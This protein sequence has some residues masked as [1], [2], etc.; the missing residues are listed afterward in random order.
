V[1]KTFSTFSNGPFKN[2]KRTVMRFGEFAI[3]P[4]LGH[5][6]SC[7]RGLPTYGSLAHA[8]DRPRPDQHHL[9]EEQILPPA[10][11]RQL[12]ICLTIECGRQDLFLLET[13]ST[14]ERKIQ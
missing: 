1:D 7:L 4:G 6:S 12:V 13:R 9:Q 10:F 2:T 11:N 14:K 3:Q 5:A 8:T